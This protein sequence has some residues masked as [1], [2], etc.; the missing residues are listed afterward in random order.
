MKKLL[1]FFLT[2]L[3]ITQSFS[4]SIENNNDYF[5]ISYKFRFSQI[6]RKLP[7]KYDIIFQNILSNGNLQNLHHRN[8][9]ESSEGYIY[10][11]DNT[12]GY[13][14]VENSSSWDF[15]WK[16]ECN[17]DSLNNIAEEINYSRNKNEGSWNE[18]RKYTYDN[19]YDSNGNLTKRNRFSF[20]NGIEDDAMLEYN[21]DL[22]GNLISGI[23]YHYINSTWNL[24][25]KWELIYDEIFKL[26]SYTL[27]GWDKTEAKWN[28]SL[29]DE[30]TYDSNNQFIARH[31]YIWD[32]VESNWI[33][34]Q[35]TEAI[36]DSNTRS[37]HF[38]SYE[39]NTNTNQWNLNTSGSERYFF[40]EN[41]NLIQVIYYDSNSNPTSKHEYKYDS[42]ISSFIFPI[43]GTW[44]VRPYN[45]MLLEEFHYGWSTSKNDWIEEGKAEYHYTQISIPTYSPYHIYGKE[46]FNFPNPFSSETSITIQ[47]PKAGKLRMIVYNLLGEQVDQ[48]SFGFQ[49][50]GQKEFRYNSQSLQSGTFI[51]KL[52]IDG[53]PLGILKLVKTE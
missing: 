26:I 37:Y 52:Y 32:D 42:D 1:L 28:K 46:T 6:K 49:I 47:I 3:I 25:D 2:S 30:I 33:S 38:R 22:N 35:K 5:S 19:F 12:I 8:A 24:E 41:W 21:Y 20:R 36:Y 23:S 15:D 31:D 48:I 53:K 18:E 13:E 14:W 34:S 43:Q 11:L 16:T 29:K 4:Q 50:E 17:Y 7:E 27:Y 9:L 44:I 45:N 51:S 40:D 10:R 39:W